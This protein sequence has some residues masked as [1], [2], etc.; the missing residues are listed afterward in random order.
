MAAKW[1]QSAVPVAAS[2]PVAAQLWRQSCRWR[3]S[4][5]Q[6]WRQRCRWRQSWR[7]R[8]RWRQSRRLAAKPGGQAW[9]RGHDFRE[10]TEAQPVRNSSVNSVQLSQF[11]QF[12]QFS[13]VVARIS[14]SQLKRNLSATV[15]SVSSVSSVQFSSVQFSYR[16]LR[17]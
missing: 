11:S 16:R 13:S 10:T 3:H 2:M 9:R 1:R 4:W 17:V 8:C 15:Q 7:Q 14:G 6:S 12:S 5:R